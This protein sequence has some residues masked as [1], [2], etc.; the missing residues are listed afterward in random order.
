MTTENLF[1]CYSIRK[2]IMENVSIT[3]PWRAT[4][5]FSQ[6]QQD[7]FELVADELSILANRLRSMVAAEVSTE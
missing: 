5:S 2:L 6:E 1:F 4:F 3:I 7:P